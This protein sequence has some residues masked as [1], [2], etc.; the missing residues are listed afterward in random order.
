MVGYE[1]APF[2]Q[3][4]H[5]IALLFQTVDQDNSGHIDAKDLGKAL[6]N[7]GMGSFSQEACEMMINMVDTNLTGTI[8]INEF[9]KLIMDIQQWKAMFDGSDLDRSG[10][11]NQEEF[12]Q[13]LQKMGYR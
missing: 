9:G 1:G 2:T 5:R 12:N 6:A 7:G 4:D 13:A 11:L 10:Q 8:D 3:A